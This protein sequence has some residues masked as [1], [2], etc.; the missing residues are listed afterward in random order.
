MQLLVVYG[1][2]CS[3]KS[4]FIDRLSCL[5]IHTD[6]IYEYELEREYTVSNRPK[7]GTHPVNTIDRMVLSDSQ[8]LSFI[9]KVMESEPGCLA[10]EGKR[11][12]N[13]YILEQLLSVDKWDVKVVVAY[14]SPNIIQERFELSGKVLSEYYTNA[15]TSEYECRDRFVEMYNRLS[16]KAPADRLVLLNVT[17][18]GAWDTLYEDY[19]GYKSSKYSP[20]DFEEILQRVLDEPVDNGMEEFNNVVKKAKEDMGMPHKDYNLSKGKLKKSD[21]VK[22]TPVQ[23]EEETGDTAQDSPTFDTPAGKNLVISNRGFNAVSVDTPWDALKEVSKMLLKAPS[24]TLKNLY[25][26]IEDTSQSYVPD[27][28]IKSNSG[29]L[30]WHLR[31]TSDLIEGATNIGGGW[32]IRYDFTRVNY[33]KANGVNDWTYKDHSGGRMN[34]EGEYL[35]PVYPQDDMIYP[36]VTGR[37]DGQGQIHFVKDLLLKDRGTDMAI[38]HF[39]D[40]KRDLVQYGVRKWQ[41]NPDGKWTDAQYQRVPCCI[42]WH[43][44]VDKGVNLSA[45][46]R[47]MNTFTDNYSDDVYRYVEMAR[48]L[49]GHLK[50]DSGRLYLNIGIT[51]DIYYGKTGRQRAIARINNREELGCITGVFSYPVFPVFSS[52]E[53]FSEEWK[54]K[55][56]AEYNYRLGA[57]QEG[58]EFLSKLNSEYY[59]EWVQ[60]MR[61]AEIMLAQRSL[62]QLLQKT[63]K[64]DALPILKNRSVNKAWEYVEGINF[65]DELNK[66]KSSHKPCTSVEVMNYLL[67][68]DEGF[69][70]T[71]EVL[72]LFPKEWRDNLLL[73]SLRRVDKVKSKT[74]LDKYIIDKKSLL[75]TNFVEDVEGTTTI[76]VDLDLTEECKDEESTEEKP[77]TI[78]RTPVLSKKPEDTPEPQ[79]SDDSDLLAEK[80]KLDKKI[81]VIRGLIRDEKDPDSIDALEEKLLALKKQRRAIRKVLRKVT[82]SGDSDND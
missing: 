43:F 68:L 13:E 23:E 2:G 79:D 9:A 18:F 49:G 77:V 36:Q 40:W 38:V 74:L 21:K 7:K 70:R 48:W 63:G 76:I 14:Y 72:E 8:K 16:K 81:K 69:E 35:Y 37:V 17:D 11:F 42:N 29:G 80:A 62:G 4:D 41:L 64:H 31:E 33:L 60:V 27:Y 71:L 53:D 3:G 44:N 34:A 65:I 30:F 66:L 56:F 28:P 22:D 12:F 67:R 51:K 82:D 1:A 24:N 5:S 6:D 78:V 32:M 50:K 25:I 58:D 59:K 46:S 57:F 54:N 61:I 15:G 47:S 26:H 75:Q 19:K 55:E 73:A 39:W 20:P 10:I 45:N 52:P